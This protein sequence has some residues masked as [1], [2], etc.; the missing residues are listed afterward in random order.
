MVRQRP[1][2]SVDFLPGQDPR[3]QIKLSRLTR[4]SAAPLLLSHVPR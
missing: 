1:A 4:L 3:R 2:W